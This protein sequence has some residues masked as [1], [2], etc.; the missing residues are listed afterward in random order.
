MILDA[1]QMFDPPGTPRDLAQVVGTYASLNTLDYGILSGIPSSANGGGARDMGVGGPA[2]KLFAQVAEAFDSAGAA[3]LQVHLQGAEDDGNGDPDTF[4]TWW[5]SPAYA[6]TDIDAVG[7]Q[8]F[9][10]DFPRPPQGAPIPRFVRLLYQVAGATTTAGAVTAGVVL[11][12]PDQAYNAEDNSILGGY[13]A[14]LNV[15]N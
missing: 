11:D 13:P 12:R 9:S 2:L 8:L 14:G 4:E 3:T 1:L 10:M 6:L 15:A 5:S 7:A